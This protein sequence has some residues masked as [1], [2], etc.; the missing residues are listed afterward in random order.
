MSILTGVQ[1]GGKMAARLGSLIAL[2][3]TEATEGGAPLSVFS[4][5]SVASV[6]QPRRPG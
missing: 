2:N 4:V 5:P 6:V 3:S 1:K